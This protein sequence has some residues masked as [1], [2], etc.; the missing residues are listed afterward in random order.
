MLIDVGI[1]QILKEPKRKNK[2]KIKK[3]RHTIIE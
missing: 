1:E 3:Q 2:L